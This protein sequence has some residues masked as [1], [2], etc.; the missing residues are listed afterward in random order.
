MLGIT[1]PKDNAVAVTHQFLKDIGAKVTLETVEET[2]TIHPDYPSLLSITE[3]L[4]DWKIEN[5][6]ASIRPE[7]LEELEAPFL[8]YLTTKG[9]IFILVK[10][11]KDSLIEWSDGISS[12]REKLSDFIP[13]CNGVILMAEANPQSREIDY[14]SNRTKELILNIRFPF[15]AITAL[16]L[17]T[18]LFYYQWSTNLTYNFFLITKFSGTLISS[19]LLW[20]SIDK[21]NPF[22]Q[23]LCQING[24]ADCKG[25]LNSDAAKVSSWLSWSEI[26]F[27]Y[28]A[29]GF[30][31][32]I[33]EPATI[34]SLSYLAVPA[35]IYSIWSVY[36]QTLVAKQ[37]CMLCLLIQL[38]ICSEFAVSLFN[39]LGP[40]YIHFNDLHNFWFLLQG[41]LAAI[42]FWVF[43]KPFFQSKQ[44]IDFVKKDLRRFKYNAE[45]FLGLLHNQPPLKYVSKEMGAIIWGNPEAE[46]T[47]TIVTNPLCQPCAKT[48]KTIHKLLATCTNLNCQVIFSTNGANRHK[49]EM[50][51]R[52]ILSFPEEEQADALNK[53]FEDKDHNV[54]HWQTYYNSSKN[55][56]INNIL[57][58]QQE[59]CLA[60]EITA[61]PSIFIDGFKLP[62]IY[63][64]EELGG[65]LKQ[66]PTTDFAKS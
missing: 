7:R 8:T 15:I 55:E 65:I 61:T 53:W 11:I 62:E 50:I 33:I 57:A 19:L 21:N 64:L 27:F 13:N 16:I 25:I 17:I 45:I 6:T 22:I 51:A 48:H 18:S 23:N 47:I 30:I 38:I 46:H 43:F 32:L 60:S 28:F 12:K 52:A 37:W 1:Q 31:A 34:F 10:S 14:T 42:V 58:N 29:G 66:L 3:A 35:I 59:W 56:E 26:G 54:E 20:Q 44:E 40:E 36:Y 4:E 9:G 24:R 49:R 41:S 2:L 63:R 5:I 39:L